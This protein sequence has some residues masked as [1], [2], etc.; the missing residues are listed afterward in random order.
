MRDCRAPGAQAQLPHSPVLHR[1]KHRAISE[2]ECGPT[3]QR[4]AGSRSHP[5]GSTK[6]TILAKICIRPEARAQSN[7]PPRWANRWA[8]HWKFPATIEVRLR[9]PEPYLLAGIA[10]GLT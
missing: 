2:M 10:N 5:N 7:H 3:G 6:D 4:T 9:M 8:L 1:S